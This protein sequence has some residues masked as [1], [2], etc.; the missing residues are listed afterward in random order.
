[1]VF[2]VQTSCDTSHVTGDLECVHNALWQVSAL[3]LC[4]HPTKCQHAR[5]FSVAWG[6]GDTF[7]GPGDWATTVQASNLICRL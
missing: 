7:S 3:R 5:V 2:E 6:D 4:S 1:M